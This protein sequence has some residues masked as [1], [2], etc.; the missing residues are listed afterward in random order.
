MGKRIMTYFGVHIPPFKEHKYTANSTTIKF[1]VTG[2][3]PSKKNNQQAV[4]IRK[5]ARDW[6]KEQQRAGKQPTWDDVQKAISM[7]SS[8]MRGNVK[9]LLFLETNKT[10]IQK[11]MQFWSERLFDKG[12]TF[13]IK[14]AT[15]SLRF[16]FKDR[17]IRDTCNIQQS[18][19]DLLVDCGVIVDDNYNALNPI[20]AQSACYPD[21]I[22]ENIASITLTFNINA[23]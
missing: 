6:A 8:K 9:Y 14:R 4:T 5:Y 21:E 23:T 3:I 18:I 16:Y 22:L 12:L 15:L 1:V 17:Y 2:D 11:Q 7:T 10:L 19:Q 13:P 20:T